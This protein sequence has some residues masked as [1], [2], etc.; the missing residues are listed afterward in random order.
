MAS[1]TL[2]SFLVAII[3]IGYER[4]LISLIPSGLGSAQDMSLLVHMR[5]WKVGQSPRS[6][7]AK[8]VL[9]S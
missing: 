6:R 7:P 8:A 3:V 9:W 2:F 4:K 1:A 5:F